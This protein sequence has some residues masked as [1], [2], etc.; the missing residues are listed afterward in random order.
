MEYRN[1]C[2]VQQR[3]N[4]SI[5]RSE[6]K[7]PSLGC[8]GFK[9]YPFSSTRKTGSSQASRRQYVFLSTAIVHVGNSV[10]KHQCLL[11]RY[12]AAKSYFF[13]WNDVIPFP[14]LSTN[15]YSQSVSI[16]MLFTFF[17][18]QSCPIT[19]FLTDSCSY[20]LR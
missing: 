18:S 2:S 3:N 13:R 1:W 9:T 8:L 14:P 11:P 16:N 12:A 7:C 5:A 19:M 17:I 15:M 4:V 6:K 20:F 10:K